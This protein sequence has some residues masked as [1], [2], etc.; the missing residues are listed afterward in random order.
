MHEDVLRLIENVKNMNTL[1]VRLVTYIEKKFGE[2]FASLFATITSLKNSLSLE[3]NET[4]DMLGLEGCTWWS[5]RW[6]GLKRFICRAFKF[7]QSSLSAVTHRPTNAADEGCRPWIETQ[8]MSL[9]L[10]TVP[11]SIVSFIL[12]WTF[13]PHNTNRDT[14]VCVLVSNIFWLISIQRSVYEYRWI[15]SCLWSPHGQFTCN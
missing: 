8:L 14:F 7:R 10:F 9:S 13:C 4:W 6:S 1:A 15:K 2:L 12:C 3:S 5:F 11:S